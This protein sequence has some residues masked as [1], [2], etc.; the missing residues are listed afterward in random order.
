MTIP[1]EIDWDRFSSVV[2]G[3]DIVWNFTN[4]LFGSDPVFY[5]AHPCHRKTQFVVYTPSCGA[6]RVPLRGTVRK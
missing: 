5:G 3:A 1:E 6:V 2:V 4:P